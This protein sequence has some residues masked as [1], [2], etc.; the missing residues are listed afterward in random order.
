LQ[1]RKNKPNLFS[2]KEGNFLCF[3]LSLSP[4]PSFSCVRVKDPMSAEDDS[5]RPIDQKMQMANLK[6][7]YFGRILLSIVMGFACGILN[8]TGLCSQTE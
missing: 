3:T 2:Q 5:R 4:S 1:L 8:M 6:T 7:V